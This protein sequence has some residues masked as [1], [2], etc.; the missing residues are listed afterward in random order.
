MDGTVVNA[1]S[2][3]IMG[4][5]GVYGPN[6]ANAQEVNIQT[7]GARDESET[8]GS[9][10][11]IVPRTGGY[12]FAGNY[13]TTYTRQVWFGKDTT[14]HIEVN[15]VGSCFKSRTSPRLS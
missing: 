7:S 12:R 11:N 6:I 14:T 4:T 15:R 8:G 9:A 3:S 13:A 5:T 1:G 10:I 2:G